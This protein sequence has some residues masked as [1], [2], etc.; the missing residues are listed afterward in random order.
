MFTKSAPYYDALY[1]MKDYEAACAGLHEL[2]RRLHP[3]AATLLDIGCGTGK[4]LEHLQRHYRVEGLDVNPELLE[5]A[6]RR[7]PSARF[8]LADMIDFALA[9]RFDV[10]TCLFSSIAYVRT[11][12]NL[13]RTVSN[14][15]HHLRPGGLLVIEPWFTPETYWTGTITANFVDEPDRKIAW[16]YTSERAGFLSILNIH[17]LV[18]T[19]RGVE[20]FTELHEFGLFTHAEYIASVRD[21]GLKVEHDL[22]G[23]FGRGLYLGLSLRTPDEP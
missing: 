2:V 5:I 16:M 10:V 13:R 4:H 19:P 18:G 20:Y 15:A 1:S 23:L 11:V 3:R 8:H 21:L 22:L 6:R 7:C 9:T 14:M 12:E 17:Y